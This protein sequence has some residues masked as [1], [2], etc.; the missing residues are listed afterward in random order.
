[1]RSVQPRETWAK[2][3]LWALLGVLY[4]IAGLAT[5]Q[6]PLLAAAFVTLVIG[7]SLMASGLVRIVLAFSMKEGTPW[8]WVVL[9][10]LV[11]V[12]LGFV[13]LDHWPVS[14]L[15]ILG[16]LLGIDLVFTGTTWIGVGFGLR[17]KDV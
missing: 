4:I 11:T 15:Y 7:M 1:M 3:V 6:N 12:V 14:S 2:F 9:S 10:G 16:L 17:R 8:V 13:I 5:F